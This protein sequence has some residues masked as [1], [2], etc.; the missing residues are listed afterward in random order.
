[1]EQASWID[2]RVMCAQRGEDR[3]LGDLY[4]LFCAPLT[5]LGVRWVTSHR[6]SGDIAWDIAVEVLLRC[7]RRYRID[8]ASSASFKTYYFRALRRERIR[9][10]RR[11]LQSLD[12]IEIASSE[13]SP[14][15][16][17]ARRELLEHLREGL[18]ALDTPIAVFLMAHLGHG[19]PM[20]HAYRFTPY[21]YDYTRRMKP[22]WLERLRQAMEQV[23][24]T[25]ALQCR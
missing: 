22:I 18:E 12:N 2:L 19:I 14:S 3:A 4:L 23:T 5:G 11:R 9:V 6:V 17:V 10:A 24:R 16:R 8:H 1:M 25:R 21:S 20:S 15:S 13:P 7:L